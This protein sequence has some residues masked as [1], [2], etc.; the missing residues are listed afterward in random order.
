M[1]FLF[2]FDVNGTFVTQI[3]LIKCV[4]F[5]SYYQTRLQI[6]GQKHEHTKLRYTGMTDAFVQIRRQEGVK[7]L[8]SG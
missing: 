2:R 5:F 8:Y 7:A 6:Q 3:K 4:S 1:I